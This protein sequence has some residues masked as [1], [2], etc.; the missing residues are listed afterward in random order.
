MPAAKREGLFFGT[1][2]CFGMVLVMTFYNMWLNGV[3]TTVTFMELLLS[4]AAGFVIALSLD[5]FV[6]GPLARKAASKVFPTKTKKIHM[7]LKMFAFM[8]FGMKGH[9]VCLWADYRSSARRHCRGILAKRV[10][11]HLFKEFHCSLP[12]TMADY[13]ANC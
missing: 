1:M 3:L 2:M 10:F 6:V 13:G 7:V 5:L 11:V 4:F 12:I 8:V 9:Y